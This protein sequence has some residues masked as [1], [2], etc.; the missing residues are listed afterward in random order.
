MKCP[1]CKRGKTEVANSRTT[2]G[3]ASVW[4]RRTCTLCKKTFSTYETT[5]LDFLVVK[6][7]SGRNTRYAPYKIF[8]SVFDAYAQGKGSDGK[9][10]DRGDAAKVAHAVLFRVEEKILAA[11]K[12]IVSTTDLVRLVGGELETADRA[13]FYRYG[14]FSPH[15]QEVLGL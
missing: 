7:R 9:M 10:R 8:A 4:R 2:K 15:K 14:A 1:F 12:N 13:A 5:S 11:G 6:K 3:G